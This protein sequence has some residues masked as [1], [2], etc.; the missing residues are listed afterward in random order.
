MCIF[1]SLTGYTDYGCYVMKRDSANTHIRVNDH[2]VASSSVFVLHF[3][4]QPAASIISFL[5]HR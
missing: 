4:P 1:K 5:V 3:H 2:I